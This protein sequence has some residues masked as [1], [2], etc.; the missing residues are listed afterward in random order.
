MKA[1]QVYEAVHFANRVFPA[2]LG[3][4]AAALAL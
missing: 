3:L 4:E 1:Q 2:R